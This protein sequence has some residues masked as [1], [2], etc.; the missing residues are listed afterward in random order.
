MDPLTLPGVLDSL[1]EIG[2]YVN[3]AA[4]AAGLEKKVAYRLRLAVDEVATNSIIHGYEESGTTGDLVVRSEMDAEKLT[5]IVEDS[6]PPF[7]LRSL[8]D[9]P[10]H[11]DRPVEDRPIGGLGVYLTI[12]NVD[13]F[14]YE[15]VNNRNRNI[16]IVNRPQSDGTKPG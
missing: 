9:R 3:A 8:Q 7:D 12:Q 4:Q 2:Q 11:I 16:F 6:A 1:S 10:D 5:I 15:Y 14:D 13:K